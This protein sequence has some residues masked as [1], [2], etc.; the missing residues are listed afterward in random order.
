MLL[1]IHSA[2]SFPYC[3]QILLTCPFIGRTSKVERGWVAAHS[4]SA[5]KRQSQDQN[6]EICFKSMLQTLTETSPDP[7]EGRETIFMPWSASTSLPNR[8]EESLGLNESGRIWWRHVW[9]P[10]LKSCGTWEVEG[11]KREPEGV[12]GAH[13]RKGVILRPRGL[14]DGEP[15]WQPRFLWAPLALETTKPKCKGIYFLRKTH[16]YTSWVISR[17]TRKK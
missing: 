11:P 17:G 13:R 3:G 4:S 7:G 16:T 6:L 2:L 5:S 1:S 14:L 12:V 15:S 8:E 9:P 10:G